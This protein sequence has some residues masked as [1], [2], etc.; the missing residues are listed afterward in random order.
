MSDRIKVALVD[1]HPLFRQGVAHILAMQPDIEVVGQGG[2]SAEAI[3][4]AAELSP[5]LVVLDISMPGGGIEAARA[6]SSGYPHVGVVMLTVSEEEE[7]VTAALES[8]ALAYVLKGASGRELVQV[9]RRA[10]AG[11]RYVSPSLVPLL[12]DLHLWDC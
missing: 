5:H 7:D 12:G 2:S 4:L 8:G 9:L 6:I 3:R 1:D 10:R 11:C